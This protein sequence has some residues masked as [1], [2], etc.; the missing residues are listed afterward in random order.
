MTS[1]EIKR[2]IA[3]LIGKNFFKFGAYKTKEGIEFK[4][5]GEKME[6]GMPI[7]VITPQGE[8]PVTEGEYEME[9][10]MKIKVAEGAI[11]NIE[12]SLNTGGT[13]I[14][15]IGSE[16]GVDSVDGE[17][18][19]KTKM[20]EATLVDGTVVGTD[21]DFEVGKKLYVKDQEGSWV[22]APTGEHTTESGIV[23]VVD[24][25]GIITGLSKPDG[26]KEGSLSNEEMSA[27]DLVSLFTSAVKELTAS[28]NT[29]RSE[30]SQLKERFEKV[31]A[32]PAG[33]RVYDRKGYLQGLEAS[34]FNKIDQLSALKNRK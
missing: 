3:E 15:E 5:D 26:E 12:D 20:D 10:G 31:A 9:S 7:Y 34:K 4:I 30:H 1:N 16:D 24:E 17:D 22:Q 18:M 13:P 29:L 32:S 19:S 23:L 11:T 21:G 6:V 14:D 33:E 28:I 27:E 25:A 8:L 2:K